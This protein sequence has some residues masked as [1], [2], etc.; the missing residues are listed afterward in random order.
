MKYDISVDENN[1]QFVVRTQGPIKLEVEKLML[2]EIVSH[3]KW[4]GRFNLLFDHSNST[5]EHLQAI[6]IQQLSDL[7][8]QYSESFGDIKIA[9]VLSTDLNYGLGRMWQ[10]YT[11]CHVSCDMCIFRTL[12]D[13]QGWLQENYS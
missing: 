1:A 2:P 5:L 4:N 13:A 3:P 11:S 7:I 12:E 10:A 9:I 6:D 8:R